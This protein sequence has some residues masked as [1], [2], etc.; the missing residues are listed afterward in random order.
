M[1]K[2]SST[3]TS[4][5]VWFSSPVLYLI[6]INFIIPSPCCSGSDELFFWVI[7]LFFNKVLKSRSTFELIVVVLSP[8]LTVSKNPVL[9]FLIVHDIL[10]KYIKLTIPSKPIIWLFPIESYWFFV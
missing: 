6:S 7:V 9:L 4:I 2:L 8:N 3:T 5:S 10:D 1:K